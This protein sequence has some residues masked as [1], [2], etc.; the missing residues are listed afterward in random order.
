MPTAML[1][2]IL[3]ALALLTSAPTAATAL[4]SRQQEPSP[5][6]LVELDL[7]LAIDYGQDRV[8][9]RARLR[10]HHA[11]TTAVDRVPILLNRLLAVSG[12]TDE[13]GRPLDFSQRIVGFDDYPKLQVDYTTIAL[14]APVAP[15][16]ELT[17]VVTYAGSLVGY[18]ET[19][20]L[21]IRDHL[22]PAFTILRADAY[23][24]PVVSPPAIA[25]LRA[26]LPRPFLFR[27][28]IT[29]PD[30]LVVA[31]SGDRIDR[32]QSAAG[33]STWTYRSTA[34]V[35]FLN[36][37]IAPYAMLERDGVQSFFF[38]ADSAG[39]RLAVDR[40]VAG[41]ALLTR[42]FGP[43][44]N[45]AR[46]TVIEIPD[47]WGSQA[48]LTGGIIQTAA[49]FRDPQRSHEI[50]HE[51]SHLWNPPD[52]GTFSPRLNEGLASFLEWRM[53][54]ALDGRSA[55][56]SIVDLRAATLIQRAATDPSL[57]QIPMAAY[58]RERRTDLS[59]R[60]GML[61]FYAI[62]R[63][64][65]P[66]SFNALWR[67]YYRKSRTTGGSDLDFAAFAARS[68]QG[69]GRPRATRLGRLFDEWFFTTRWLRRLTAGESMTAIAATCRGRP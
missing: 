36:I 10:L 30:S 37:T 6:Q 61:L 7:A 22:D 53:A 66:D 33:R 21:Y 58:G 16:S 64:I 67:D 12:V 45:P 63:C 43:L 41:I 49:A 60:V 32:Q 39:A 46:L 24:F 9:G 62:E 2:L 50:Y 44:E 26:R 25:A 20:A 27:A 13:D 34:P 8:S 51:L 5:L 3:L 47:G 11:G 55:L 19:G 17:V 29:V 54:D 23:A 59:Y 52:T 28:A 38:H 40:A 4:A 65:G 42:W 18:T 1:R 15:G 35:P 14:G 69:P 57:A 48:S 68:S 31:T 56:D